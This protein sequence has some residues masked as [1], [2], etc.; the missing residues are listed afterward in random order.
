MKKNIYWMIA[1]I[2]TS[3][4]IM[5]STSCGGNNEKKAQA[6]A[7]ATVDTVAVEVKRDTFPADKWMEENKQ[8]E[9]VVEKD[10][11]QYRILKEGTGKIPNKRMRVRMNFDLRLTNGK[12]VES[13]QG[14]DVMELPISRLIPGL[15]N[16]LRLM[17]EGS[18]WEVYVPWDLGYGEEGAKNVPP[19]S[20][21]IF[22]VHLIEIVK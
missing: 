20:A 2:L 1:A 14:K 19:H 9:G 11:I 6:E 3:G 7:E 5:M 21:L 15:Q 22:K 17:P 18:T 8:K 16:A 12:V 4:T 13:H 10:G